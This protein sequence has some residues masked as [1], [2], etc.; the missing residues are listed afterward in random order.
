MDSAEI[1]RLI[2]RI[3]KDFSYLL[4]GLQVEFLRAPAYQA[5]I[6]GKIILP[7]EQSM[8]LAAAVYPLH[9]ILETNEVLVC[10]EEVV[11]LL[12]RE[13]EQLQHPLVEGLILNEILFL[14][15]A[16]GPDPDPRARAEAILSRYW[17]LQYVTLY[18][19]TLLG[20]QESDD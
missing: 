9:S 20:Q 2:S 18:G 15:V 19:R 4:P 10:I 17:P 7:D 13:A 3:V 12:G 6:S 11:A 1:E 8:Q 5:R 14:A 16:R